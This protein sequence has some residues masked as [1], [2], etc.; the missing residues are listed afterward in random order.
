MVFIL[1]KSGSGKSTLLN[2]LGGL[3]NCDSGE[4]Y[5][6]SKKISNFKE[7]DYDY[8]RNTY[9]GFIFQEFNLIEEYNVYDNISLGL[10]LQK[11]KV[12]KEQLDQILEQVGLTGLGLRKI[13]ELSG[14]QKQRVAIARALIKNP[15]M[16]L[17]DEPTGSL[18]SET[19]KQIFDLLGISKLLN[20]YEYSI[21]IW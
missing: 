20:K 18:D 1:G 8:Y 16:I 9:V 19:G 13:N 7:N 10:K 21:K 3:D 4:I 12:K 5:V 2:I 11:E 6:D 15:N 14:G 17:A